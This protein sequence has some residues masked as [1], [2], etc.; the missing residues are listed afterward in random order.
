[1][2][3]EVEPE[4]PTQGRAGLSPEGSDVMQV[5]GK[6]FDNPRSSL[7]IV[8]LAAG[9]TER[10][11]GGTGRRK[12]RIGRSNP[13]GTEKSRIVQRSGSRDPNL[14]PERQPA[15]AS[16]VAFERQARTSSLA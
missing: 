2:T 10:S 13:V 14:I 16:P 9:A 5:A 6:S 15:Y 4:G 3:G 11:D 7:A 1:M 12:R 8:L